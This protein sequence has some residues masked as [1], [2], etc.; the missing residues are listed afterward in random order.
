MSQNLQDIFDTAHHRKF[1]SVSDE[2]REKIRL[3][4]L[5]KQRKSYASQRRAYDRAVMTP[6][7]ATTIWVW[8]EQLVAKGVA[9]DIKAAAQHIRFK[10]KHNPTEY[11]YTKEIK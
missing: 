4:N 11:Y 5:G 2:Q 6:A 8:R 9:K 7:G 10:L 3:A 1:V